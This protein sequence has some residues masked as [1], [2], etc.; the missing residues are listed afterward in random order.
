MHLYIERKICQFNLNGV[1]K[2]TSV[3]FCHH[4]HV[5]I[6]VTKEMEKKSFECLSEFIPKDTW[7]WMFLKRTNNIV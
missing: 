6:H 3:F 7:T 5:G 4:V 2:D 1:C